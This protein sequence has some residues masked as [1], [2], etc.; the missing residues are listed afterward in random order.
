MKQVSLSCVSARAQVVK[1]TISAA[2]DPVRPLDRGARDVS[3]KAHRINRSHA[4]VVTTAA[5]FFPLF[6][7]FNLAARGN[8][9]CRATTMPDKH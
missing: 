6:S 8:L 2:V 1:R 4:P 3:R 5:I 7:F 9:A